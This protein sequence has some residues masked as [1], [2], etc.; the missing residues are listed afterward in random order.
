MVR[1]IEYSYS[2]LRICDRHASCPLLHQA[3]RDRPGTCRRSVESRPGADLVQH[4]TNELIGANTIINP[5]HTVSFSK[6]GVLSPTGS[7]KSF[8]ASADGYARYAS[9]CS[10][11][12]FEGD[13]YGIAER[14]VLLQFLS[15]GLIAPFKMVMPSTPSSPAARSTPTEKARV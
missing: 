8:D 1:L 5:E 13:P 4:L 7:S 6:L 14:R 12:L 3:W 10:R 11:Y 15:N 2:V 9:S